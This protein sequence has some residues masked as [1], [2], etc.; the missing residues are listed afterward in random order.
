[1]TAESLYFTGDGIGDQPNVVLGDVDTVRTQ[2]SERELSVRQLLE[3]QA[4]SPELALA[5]TRGARSMPA[6]VANDVFGLGLV[7]DFGAN[8]GTASSCHFTSALAM[9]LVISTRWKCSRV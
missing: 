8:S 3:H 7:F 1:M 6:S 5:V 9:P 2:L 4:W